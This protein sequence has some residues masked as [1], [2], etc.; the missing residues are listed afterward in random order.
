LKSTWSLFL[1]DRAVRYSLLSKI[2]AF[3]I[4]PLTLVSIGTF[5]RPEEQGV[6]YV[7]GSLL[8][9]GAFID[10]GFSK[11]AQQ[12]LAHAF[13]QLAIEPGRGFSGKEPRLDK[14]L[15]TAKSVFVIYGLLGWLVFL[16]LGPIGHF[17]LGQ[18]LHSSMANPVGPWWVMIASIGFSF[19]LLSVI[20]VAEAANLLSLTN[21]WRLISEISGILA[22]LLVLAAGGGLWASVALSWT[23]C[24]LTIVP[25]SIALGTA[26]W[27]QILSA[28]RSDFSY[29]TDILPLQ[30]RNMVG[31]GM[32]FLIFYCYT[33]ITLSLLGPVAT[34]VVGMSIQ[35][36]NIAQ[37][38]AT[39]WFNAQIPLM[40]NLAGGG[41]RAEL[42]SLH[43][44]GTK[45][46]AVSWVCISILLIAGS[47]GCKVVFPSIGARYGTVLE[48]ALFVIGSGGFAW[49]HV[50]ATF[51]RAYR[52]EPFVVLSI[53][54][55]ALT[56]TLLFVM[57]PML[58]T[59]GAALSYA[60]T[61]MLGACWTEIAYRSFKNGSHKLSFHQHI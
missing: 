45:I 50:R 57:I 11:S 52:I 53:I 54:Q 37:N 22:F 21:K 43:A 44:K 9:L 49:T 48:I 4:G 51:L 18:S 24:L 19:G 31:Y 32:G 13:G 58:G 15:V 26:T 36:S 35:I 17:Y 39:V 47:A 6:Y 34:G 20:T 41:S 33:P 28:H 3:A 10:L 30:S 14:F 12:L 2:F 38:F 61:M 60:A 29:R 42:L 8:Q 40:G 23:R 5:L 25:V 1:T 56:V 46:T 16:I 55:A 59:L 7:F 27:R